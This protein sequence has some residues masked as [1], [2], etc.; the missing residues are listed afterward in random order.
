MKVEGVC[1]CWV[2]FHGVWG[3]I[4]ILAGDGGSDGFGVRK[5][6]NGWVFGGVLPEK[7]ENER[8]FWVAGDWPEFEG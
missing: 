3:V 1:G 5:K 6:E 8:R 7:E 4:W 2:C